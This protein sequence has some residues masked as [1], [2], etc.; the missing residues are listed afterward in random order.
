MAEELETT[1]GL[2]DKLNNVE[3]FVEEKKKPLM[4]AGGVVLVL[5]L[6]VV[7][8]FAKWLP[9]RELK[10][11]ND[12]MMAQFAFEKDSFDIALN[13][14][15]AGSNG[16]AFKG[17]V[18]VANAYSFTKTAKLA[19][20]YAGECYLNLKKYQDAITYLEKG[21]VSDPILGAVRLS[22]IGDAYSETGK[23]D[24]AINYYEK[25]ADY[26]ENDKYTPFYL[27]KAGLANEKLNKK[28]EAKKLYEKIRDNY[29]NSDEGMQIEKYIIR[30]SGS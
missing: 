1:E 27:F 28:A 20:L 2:Q 8:V 6:A 21:N 29:P 3:A 25:A 7:Y 18:Q 14:R 19:N 24:E 15:S 10:A 11:Q 30:V 13:G 16:K 23:M 17:F 4:I 9:D 26:S 12:I 5:V 22:A